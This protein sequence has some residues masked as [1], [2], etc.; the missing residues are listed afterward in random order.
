MYSS[1][2]SDAFSASFQV[3]TYSAYVAKADPAPAFRWHQRFIERHVT[4]WLRGGAPSGMSRDIPYNGVFPPVTTREAPLEE[5][6]DLFVSS[7][8]AENYAG[9]DEDADAA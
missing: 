4:A 7:I 9:L 5:A 1:F 6:D 8:W 2:L 3:P